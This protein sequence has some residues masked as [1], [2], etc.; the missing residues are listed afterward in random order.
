MREITEELRLS[1]NTVRTY[2]AR[3]LEKM[4]VKATNELIRYA[5]KHSLVE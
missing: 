1:M 4:G 2:R 3:V 5:V